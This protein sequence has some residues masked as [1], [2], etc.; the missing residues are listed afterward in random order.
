[1]TE[2]EDTRSDPTR[3]KSTS[4]HISK[5]A[6]T[7]KN[8]GRELGE[9]V[10]QAAHHQADKV[11]DATESHLH[12]FADALRAAGDQLSS[13]QSGP[14]A[15]FVAHAASGLEQL[16]RSL[17]MRSTGE[18]VDSVRQFGRDNP[19]GFIAGSVLAGLAL[20]RFAAASSSGQ[21]SP[22]AAPAP[23]SAKPRGAADVRVGG[24]EG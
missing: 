9:H 19:L 22:S 16:S 10:Q 13:N 23:S 15:E 20:G 1:M 8:D 18:M 6:E 3:G 14:A 4:A 11:K 2:K 21:Q 24:H 17:H 7:V 12:G 5:A